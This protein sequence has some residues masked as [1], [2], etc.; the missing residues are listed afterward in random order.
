MSSRLGIA[1]CSGFCDAW[2]LGE[3]EGSRQRISEPHALNASVQLP[4]TRIS[5]PN[6]VAACAAGAERATSAK[7]A[8]ISGARRANASVGPHADLPIEPWLSIPGFDSPYSRKLRPSVDPSRS[9]SS[10]YQTNSGGHPPTVAGSSN[11]L[12][13]PLQIPPYT[14]QWV[15][16]QGQPFAR[17]GDPQPTGA[18][19]P[20][21]APKLTR[22][23]APPPAAFSA[24]A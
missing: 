20:T 12:A 5:G 24:S 8:P 16:V 6:S 19:N 11:V 7:I 21:G 1:F 10:S 2:F 13:R 17:R 9:D 3:R 18:E 15:V 23:S 14:M 22:S 4:A